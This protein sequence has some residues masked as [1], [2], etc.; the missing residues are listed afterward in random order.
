MNKAKQLRLEAY[1]EGK[2]ARPIYYQQSFE[3]LAAWWRQRWLLPRSERVDG[4]HQWDHRNIEALLGKF[5][6]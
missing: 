6:D 5:L 2:N 1:L 3:A 4:W